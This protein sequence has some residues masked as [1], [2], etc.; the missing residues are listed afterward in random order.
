MARMGPPVS[1]RL[2]RCDLWNR[3]HRRNAISVVLPATFSRAKGY[4]YGYPRAYRSVGGVGNGVLFW[5]VRNPTGLGVFAILFR[6]LTDA[7]IAED[8]VEQVFRDFCI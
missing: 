4:S 5:P 7:E 3:D 6:L 8:Y 1:C 2:A